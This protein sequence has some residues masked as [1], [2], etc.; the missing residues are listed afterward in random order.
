M[1]AGKKAARRAIGIDLGTTNCCVAA[2]VDGRPQVLRSQTGDRLVPSI[3]AFTDDGRPLVGQAARRQA[4]VNARR[5]VYAVKRLLGRKLDSDSLADW[6][7]GLGYELVPSIPHGDAYARVGTRDLSPQ[8]ISAIILLELK[9]LAEERL[10][11]PVSDAVIT[12]PAYFNDAQRAATKAA[13]TIAG[14]RVTKILSEPTAAAL[15]YGIDRIDRTTPLTL[16]IFDLGGGT[17][18]ISIVRVEDGVFEVLAVA[19]DTFLGGEDFDRCIVDYLL[20]KWRETHDAELSLDAMARRRLAEAAEAAK[21]DLSTVE[22]TRIDLPFLGEHEEQPAH[23]S[24]ELSRARFEE[25]CAEPLSRLADPCQRALDDAGLLPRQIDRVLLVGGM[26]RV[27]VVRRQVAEIFGQEPSLGVNP[28]EVVA[29]GAAVQTAILAGERDDSALLDVTAHS[30]GVRTRNERMAVLIP[31]NTTIPTRATKVF[32]TTADDQ[33][34]VEIRVY[35]GEQEVVAGNE[36]LG[37]VRLSELPQGAAGSVQVEV[38]FLIDADGIVQVTASDLKT[39]KE[40]N[41]RLDPAGG[42]SNA[43]LSRLTGEHRAV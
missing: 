14:L 12:V 39:G 6:R 20:R 40:A 29:L 5:T 11:E 22:R 41:A 42:L 18:D 19:G 17:F 13:G 24:V 26:T 10:G 30:L 25:L 8:Q 15:G 35:Q 34:H 32:A 21:H 28:D 33:D 27:P 37:T 3:V 31:R 2:M 43:E 7:R 36:L 1:M 9:R 38:A 23:L 4:V 16:A